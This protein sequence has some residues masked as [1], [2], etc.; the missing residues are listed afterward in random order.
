VKI[1]NK[2]VVI[3]LTIARGD[4]KELYME[5]TYILKKNFGFQK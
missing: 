3:E 1:G 5:N 4:A 2:N